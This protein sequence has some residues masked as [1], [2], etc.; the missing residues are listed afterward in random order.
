MKS[1][2]F[3]ALFT[4]IFCFVFA[5][6]C[7]SQVRLNGILITE[8]NQP[9]EFANLSLRNTLS[10]QLFNTIADSSGRFSFLIP[11]GD[12]M[13]EAKL[14]GYESKV[15][16]YT[17]DGNV[18]AGSIYLKPISSSLNNVTVVATQPIIRRSADRFIATIENVITLSSKSA[19]EILNY[20]PGVQASTK[21]ISINGMGDARIY[22]DGKLVRLTGVQLLEYL[23]TFQA[24]DIKR[25]EIIPHPPSNYD[26]AGLGGVIEITT[27]KSTIK[28]FSGNFGA[29]YKQGVYPGALLN[30]NLMYK[31]G[32]LLLYSNFSGTSEKTYLNRFTERSSIGN[33]ISFNTK[34]YYKNFTK[35]YSVKVGGDLSLN[36]NQLLGIELINSNRKKHFPPGIQETSVYNN[37]SIESFVKGTQQDDYYSPMTSV[38][39]F[40][41]I[42]LD[43]SGS[44]LKLVSDYSKSEYNSDSWFNNT[45]Y[46]DAGERQKENN[47]FSAVNRRIDAYSAK[48][49]YQKTFKLLKLE[50]GIKF[51]SV[52]T[53]SNNDFRNLDFSSNKY[54]I[55]TLFSNEF[56]YN[57][58]NYAAY[59]NVSK[60]F[61]KCDIAFGLRGEATNAISKQETT[62]QIHDTSYLNLFPTFFLRYNFDS[63]KKNTLSFNVGRRIQRPEYVWLNPFIYYMD[64]FTLKTGSPYLLPTYT[65]AYE[66]TY[67]LQNK[68]F[69]SLNYYNT[70]NQVGDVEYRT[71]DLT[72]VT[73]KNLYRQ[74]NLGVNF[75][76]PLQ[77]FKWWNTTNQLQLSYYTYKDETYSAEKPFLSASINHNF[78]LTPK[79]TVSV[80]LKFYTKGVDRFEI[81][82]QNYFIAG[83]A[84]S[85]WL[86]KKKW[87]LTAGIDDIFNAYGYMKFSTYY[88]GQNNHQLYDLQSRIFSIGLRFYFKKGASMQRTNKETSNEDEKNRM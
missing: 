53:K 59:I 74:Q 62:G 21:E 7:I 2:C 28:G 12:Y 26:A 82:E 57:E 38:N 37:S 71:G 16:T 13:L 49:D 11:K 88:Q 52:N 14:L 8:K 75:Y 76:A 72:I 15:N 31:T 5:S 34:E 39:V 43:S 81:D 77:L 33:P 84:A 55:D 42:K 23:K 50:S 9:V 66:L 45:Y 40:Y 63:D 47:R 87:L 73:A 46:D 41:N 1:K 78:Q 4:S 56:N 61:S 24:S 27:S 18:D 68:Y 54:I 29:T 83:I 70:H 36:Q 85:Q 58:K 64:E 65:Y 67:G 79:S 51:S 6:K 60:S 17:I 3:I 30:G 32:K 86:Y 35:A 10:N 19:D 20:L 80:R 48:L 22:I 25:I 69:F 44:F